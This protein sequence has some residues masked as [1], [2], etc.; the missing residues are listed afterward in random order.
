MIENHQDEDEVPPLAMPEPWQ[1][2]ELETWRDL[3]QM[4]LP[5]NVE[6]LDLKLEQPISI[7]LTE[8]FLYLLIF[9]ILEDQNRRSLKINIIHLET[10]FLKITL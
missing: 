8:A 9:N 2:P 4:N 7:N 6:K 5:S 1:H 3:I 10:N